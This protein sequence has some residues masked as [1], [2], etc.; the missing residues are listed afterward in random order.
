MK[1]Y[2]TIIID[3]ESIARQRLQKL[4]NEGCFPVDVVAEAKNGIDGIELIHAL[5]P[6][7]VF[8]DVQMPGITGFQMLEELSYLPKVVFCTAYEG[9]ALKAFNTLAIDYL[10]KPVEAERL[11]LTME[12]LSHGTP[13]TTINQVAEL[14]NIIKQQSEQKKLQSIPYKIGDRVILIKTDTITYFQAAEKYVEFHTAEGKKYLTEL[15]LKR[16]H[17]KLPDNYMQVRRGLIVNLSF[18]R[19]YR[20][21]LRGKY[22]LILND[23]AGTKLETGRTFYENVQRQLSVE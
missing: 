8:L 1:T 3:D 4:F 9:Y 17:D 2:R 18:I 7:L 16:L 11:K 22:I 21:H 12:K 19:E 6:D 5:H 13:V 23:A 15:S 14:V 10:L 20:K